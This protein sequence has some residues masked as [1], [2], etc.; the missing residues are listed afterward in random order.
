MSE[1][2]Q[3]YTR[4]KGSGQTYITCLPNPTVNGVLRKPSDRERYPLPEKTTADIL[5]NRKYKDLSPAE[6]R[7]Y[8]RV[9][10][11]TIR[12]RGRDLL[13]LESTLEATLSNTA[14]LGGLASAV[15]R[16]EETQEVKKQKLKFYKRLRSYKKELEK[17]DN[18]TEQ[19][20]KELQS[21]ERIKPEDVD[22]DFPLLKIKKKDILSDTNIKGATFG[23][24]EKLIDSIKE[25]KTKKEKLK[26]TANQTQ[27]QVDK[28]KKKIEKKQ[29]GVVNNKKTVV[30]FA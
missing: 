26:K 18:P 10:M 6:K 12:H 8:H 29:A 1:R 23:N 7:D 14:K 16:N 3:C 11:A 17:I 21:Q 15:K 5:A 24:I 2:V 20:I 22:K 28:Q 4:Y 19:Q 13:G 25:L 27:D 30:S 9:Y